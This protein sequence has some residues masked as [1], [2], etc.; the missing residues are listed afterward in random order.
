MGG[1]AEQ[2][3]G[4]SASDHDA[5]AAEPSAALPDG[6]GSPNPA[7][8]YAPASPPRLNRK[9]RRARAAARRAA[10]ILPAAANAATPA[11]AD[12]GTPAAAQSEP[13]AAGSSA[14]EPAE[15]PPGGGP[16][17]APRSA[18][19]R[20]PRRAAKASTRAASGAE[21]D[22]ATRGDEH[23]AR[24]ARSADGRLPTG[25]ALA[26]GARRDRRVRQTLP[27]PTDRPPGRT[28]QGYSQRLADTPGPT[29]ETPP[30][31][32]RL[33]VGILA[34]VHGIDGELKMR[35]ATDDP[36]HLTTIQQVYVG[37][38]VRA[39]RLRGI[40]FHGGQALIRIQGVDDP[41]TGLAL[42]GQRVRIPGSDARPLAP[43]EYFL[44]QLVG[45]DVVTEDGAPLGRVADIMETGAR[46]VV[47]VAPIGGGPDILLP[48]LPDV[49]LDIDPPAG[50]MVVRPLV[51]DN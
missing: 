27:Q 4:R 35:L 36:E 10:G 22:A 9:A 18:G 14:T 24:S 43:G 31:Q 7:T 37:D 20:T 25:E 2:G 47:V 42:R 26:A 12:D 17:R 30:E 44:Y 11:P 33:T 28:G 32:V 46:D 39:R 5:T 41:E 51:Y 15:T 45:L 19:P 16:S 50:R 49:V 48:N 29:P 40:R 38:E 3:P 6:T 23:A 8:G 21:A 34:G 13:G 1:D